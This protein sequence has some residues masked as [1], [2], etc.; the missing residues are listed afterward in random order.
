[1]I[2]AI[3]FYNVRFQMNMICVI[4]GSL[5][6]SSKCVYV[7]YALPN[8]YSIILGISQYCCQPPGAGCR[9]VVV[10]CSLWWPQVYVC[11]ARWSAGINAQNEGT[12]W[13]PL[14]AATFQEHGKVGGRCCGRVWQCIVSTARVVVGIYK[15]IVHD[16]G[17]NDILYIHS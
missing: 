8:N 10:H 9:C 16:A 4:P 6:W 12:G 2:K 15:Y 17:S 5:K 11:A 14:H 13:T 7:L 1:M 3:D